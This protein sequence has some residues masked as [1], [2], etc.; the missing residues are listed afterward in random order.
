MDFATKCT[1]ISGLLDW[2]NPLAPI[3]GIASTPKATLD[4]KTRGRVPPFLRLDL[5]RYPI[6]R[7]SFFLRTSS[8][9][10]QLLYLI[11]ARTENKSNHQY[12]DVCPFCLSYCQYNPFSKRFPRKTRH[13]GTGQYRSLLLICVFATIIITY[14]GALAARYAWNSPKNL[15]VTI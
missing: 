3:I 8:G 11:V 14:P 15:S 9:V 6:E 1:L 2:F 4:C 13:S 7:K 12:P 10:S 5:D